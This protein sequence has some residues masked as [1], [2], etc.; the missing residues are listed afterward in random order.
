[1]GSATS[2]GFIYQAGSSVMLPSGCLTGLWG[3]GF[4]QL[5]PDTRPAESNPQ[6]A[7]PAASQ[8]R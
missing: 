7:W 6:S 5:L 2:P 8:V 4:S 3:L 1:M